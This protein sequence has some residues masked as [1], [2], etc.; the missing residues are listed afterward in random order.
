MHS[1][2]FDSYLKYQKENKNNVI[3]SISKMP[4][5]VMICLSIMVISLLAVVGNIFLLKSNIIYLIFIIAEF[6]SGI[7]LYF[8]TE[9]FYIKTSNTRLHTYKSYCKDIYTWLQNIGIETDA[10]TIELLRTRLNEDIETYK[11]NRKESKDRVEKWVQVLIIPIILAVFTQAI[12]D[13][14]NIESLFLYT[15]MLLLMVGF[16]AI[17]CHNFYNFIDFTKKRKIEQMISLANDLQGVLDTQINNRFDKPKIHT[18]DALLPD[19]K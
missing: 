4:V 8:F 17:I 15:T 19:H 10:D 3:K 16:I 13:N 14:T 2:V 12:S 6:I 7:T 1:I 5:V 9:N 11:V 18:T